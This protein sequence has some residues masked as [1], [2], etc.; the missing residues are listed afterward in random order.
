[1]IDKANHIYTSWS[2]GQEVPTIVL[3]HITEDPYSDGDGNGQSNGYYQQQYAQQQQQKQQQQ[4]QQQQQAQN[5]QANSDIFVRSHRSL[6]QCIVEAHQRARAIFP[7]RKPCQCSAKVSLSCPPSHSWS[8][9]PKMGASQAQTSPVL[10]P[11]L[12]AGV[13]HSGFPRMSP[14]PVGFL[15]AGGSPPPSGMN[16]G[17]RGYSPASNASHSPGYSGQGQQQQPQVF[18]GIYTQQVLPADG[19]PVPTFG[20]SQGSKLGVVD[21]INFEMGA[22]DS[23]ND[24]AAWMAFF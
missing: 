11:E 2:E 8:P 24:Q 6:T 10:P 12:P 14:A 9:L 19:P 7:L 20:L 3:K 5:G 23:K 4:Q 1:M 18:E 17:M 21:S 15:A 22:L 13:L 16:G